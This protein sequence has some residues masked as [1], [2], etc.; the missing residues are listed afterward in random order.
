[1]EQPGTVIL[2]QFIPVT[3]SDASCLIVALTVLSV[4]LNV[5][6]PNICV[7]RRRDFELDLHTNIYVVEAKVVLYGIVIIMDF[8]VGKCG[9]PIFVEGGQHIGVC[10]ALWHENISWGLARIAS[11]PG[12]TDRG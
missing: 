7:S 10:G 4:E 3:S 9:S 1:M 8:D 12:F 2:H 5:V 6:E 11:P